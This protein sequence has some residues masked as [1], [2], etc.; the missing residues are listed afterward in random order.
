MIPY[1]GM[2]VETVAG[3]DQVGW[4]AARPWPM[5]MK[6][7]VCIG[8]HQYCIIASAY[9]DSSCYDNRIALLK[10]VLKFSDQQVL[11]LGLDLPM[12]A[13]DIVT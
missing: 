4:G 8:I 3:S 13:Y 1:A 9:H 7:G 2:L 12:Q 6:D 11:E 5:I 10:L